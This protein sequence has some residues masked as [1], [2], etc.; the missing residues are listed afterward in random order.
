[1]QT[2]IGTTENHDWCLCR[3]MLHQHRRCQFTVGNRGFVNVLYYGYVY[4][5][6][7]CIGIFLI[8]GMYV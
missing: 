2:G 4:V 5:P 1:M 7:V 3:G 8:D 6:Y